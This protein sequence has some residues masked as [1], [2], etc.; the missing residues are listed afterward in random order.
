M[1]VL[2]FSSNIEG[3]PTF[4]HLSFAIFMVNDIGRWVWQ[5]CIG[6]EKQ[7]S[8]MLTNILLCIQ[9]SGEYSSTNSSCPQCP[10]RCGMPTT[11]APG[12][13][14]STVGA[15]GGSGSGGGSN[16]DRQ[17]SQQVRQLI[18]VTVLSS[19]CLWSENKYG[20]S[21]GWKT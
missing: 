13:D 11:T 2:R 15:G 4:R 18:S 7:R 19:R 9:G 21:S 20:D 5:Q 3:F 17:T 16:R 6:W 12:V 8:G 14:W 10:S 1:L